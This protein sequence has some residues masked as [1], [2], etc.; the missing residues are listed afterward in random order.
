MNLAV[1]QKPAGFPYDP[2]CL[3]DILMGDGVTME[4]LEILFGMERHRFPKKLPSVREGRKIRIPLWRVKIMDVLLTE[5]PPERK[6]QAQGG[7]VKKLW[8]KQSRSSK[9]RAHRDRKSGTLFQRTGASLLRSWLLFAATFLSD[10]LK[11][12]CQKASRTG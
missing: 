3:D 4:D 12:G 9:A 2:T 8:L 7:S 5:K 6:P 11:S 10:I 1:R